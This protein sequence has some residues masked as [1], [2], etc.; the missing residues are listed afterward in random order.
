MRMPVEF[1]VGL[2]IW[3]DNLDT[4]ELTLIVGAKNSTNCNR[5]NALLSRYPLPA[6]RIVQ[7]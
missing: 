3:R 4:G 6:A 1:P 2:G 5:F 7:R